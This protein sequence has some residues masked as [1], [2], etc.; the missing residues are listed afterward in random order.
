MLSVTHKL[1]ALLN[2]HER[3]RLYL[4]F[5][6]DLAT[7]IANVAATKTLIIIAHRL[8]TIRDGD[9]VHLL[10]HGRLA[11]SGTYDELVESQAG[12]REMAGVS[13]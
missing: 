12:F 5:T 13:G 3:K 2:S 6:A 11:A 9:V 10:D 8:A 7:A 4:L 1:L